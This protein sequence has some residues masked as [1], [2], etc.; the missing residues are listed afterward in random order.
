M[1]LQPSRQRWSVSEIITRNTAAQH[2]YVKKGSD[3]RVSMVLAADVLFGHYLSCKELE[4]EW[5]HRHHWREVSAQG[6]LCIPDQDHLA[7]SLALLDR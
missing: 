5:R 3:A 7:P 6:T 4:S 2:V 1:R